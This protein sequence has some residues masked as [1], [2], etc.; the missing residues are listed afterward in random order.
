MGRRSNAAR[1]HADLA[2]ITL[3]I[4]DEL[5]DRLGRNQWI[6]HHNVGLTVDGRDRYDVANEVETEFLIE[7]RAGYG[8]RADKQQRITI[9]GRF[10]DCLGADS[11]AGTRPVLHNEW[12]AELLR[13]ELAHQT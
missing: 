8:R 2:W 10:H 12:L 5:G 11:T 9:R 4:S 1:R 7:Q 3:G 6:Y 13:Q